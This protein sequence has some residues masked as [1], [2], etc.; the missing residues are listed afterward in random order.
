MKK[1]SN[2]RINKYKASWQATTSVSSILA[3]LCLIFDGMTAKKEDIN[4]VKQQ[5][6]QYTCMWCGHTND[7]PIPAKGISYGATKSDFTEMK[8]REPLDIVNNSQVWDDAKVPDIGKEKTV[9]NTLFHLL[10]FFLKK[11]SIVMFCCVCLCPECNYARVYF[12]T[13][14]VRI[15]VGLNNLTG[16]QVGWSLKDS[17]DDSG[18]FEFVALG[19]RYSATGVASLLLHKKPFELAYTQEQ[20]IGFSDGDFVVSAADFDNGTFSFFVNGKECVTFPMPPS[21][22]NGTITPFVGLAQGHMR[23]HFCESRFPIDKLKSYL[24]I[25]E[26]NSQNKGQYLWD[27]GESVLWQE[28]F[29]YGV[30]EKETT[31]STHP[32]QYRAHKF[33]LQIFEHLALQDL[34]QCRMCCDLYFVYFFFFFFLFNFYIYCVCGMWNH[35][36]KQSQISP[37]SKLKCYYSNKTF[38]ETTIGMML[39]LDFKQ[40]SSKSTAKKA[41]TKFRVSPDRISV[42]AWTKNIQYDS[43]KEEFTHILPLVINPTHAERAFSDI[44]KYIPLLSPGGLFTPKGALDI[45]CE[46]LNAL[47]RL[48]TILLPKENVELLSNQFSGKKVPSREQITHALSVW[49]SLHH[50]LLHLRF[51]F[52]EM[53]DQ[54]EECINKFL[55]VTSERGREDIPQLGKVVMYLLLTPSFDWHAIR[56]PLIEEQFCRDVPTYI[57]IHRQLEDLETPTKDRLRLT[58]E[59][60]E[61]SRRK[62]ML[63][64]VFLTQFGCLGGIQ[65][66][67]IF[68]HYNRT[69]GGYVGVAALRLEV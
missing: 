6:S 52:P 20:K 66:K 40:V 49:F 35:I 38:K 57:S 26:Y 45:I 62:L 39:Q 34:A 10:F 28:L 32:E 2:K 5:I 27:T 31:Q 22:R 47:S 1:N 46:L 65:V 16:A 51:L 8:G 59:S 4:T 11:K 36:L 21:F 53:V 68:D 43:A 13:E 23:L 50:L 15:H 61:K 58:F 56:R 12:E 42:L 29:R 18:E 25:E 19:N 64:F 14:I 63:L 54:A 69:Y 9:D 41:L 17:L 33:V 67:N 37:L 7:K 55:P 24:T 60:T 30:R 44:K 48:Q 3:D